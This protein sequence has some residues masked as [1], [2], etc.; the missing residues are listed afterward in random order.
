[1][2]QPSFFS[3]N[4][5]RWLRVAVSESTVQQLDVFQIGRSAL[6][7]SNLS[8]HVF[9]PIASKT[10]K[11]SVFLLLIFKLLIIIGIFLVFRVHLHKESNS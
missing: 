9:V 4:A 10:S 3:Y 5:F 7:T 1:L 8:I 2:H 11:I 6:K